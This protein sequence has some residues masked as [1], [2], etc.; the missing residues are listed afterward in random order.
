[1]YCMNHKVMSLLHEKGKKEGGHTYEETFIKW[2]G[3]NSTL[4]WS[5]WK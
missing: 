2:H 5:L 4:S 1:M 3:N